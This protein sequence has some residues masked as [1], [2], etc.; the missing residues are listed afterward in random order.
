MPVED[1]EG[2]KLFFDPDDFEQVAEC[3]ITGPQ[4]FIRRLNVDLSPRTESVG[5]YETSVEAPNPSFL[6]LEDDL[7]DVKRG[8]TATIRTTVYLIERIAFD[9]A[10]TATVYLSE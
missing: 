5:L 7:V 10:E 6:C 9:G 2:R 4:G 3:V 1:A 8:F